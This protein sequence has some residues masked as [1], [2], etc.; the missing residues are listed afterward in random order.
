[1]PDLEPIIRDL[2]VSLIDSWIDKGSVEFVDAFAVPVPVTVIAKALNV[3]DD[4]LD[5][6]KRW[7]D[8]SIAGIGTNISDD[9][10]IEAERSV[11][12][13]QHYFADQLEQR[14]TNPQ[15]DILTN[16]L[17]ARI[18]KDEDPDLPR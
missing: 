6:F 7:S 18:D 4:R 17:N 1:M 9:D 11:I 10:R 15:D 2:C 16:L 13:F 3:P 14:R 12:E 5:D 8:D